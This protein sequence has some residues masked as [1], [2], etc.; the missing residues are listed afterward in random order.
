MPSR[1]YAKRK[2]YFKKTGKYRRR[3]FKANPVYFNR[4]NNKVYRF[5]RLVN[6]DNIDVTSTIDYT[7]AYVFKLSDV[8][9]YTEFTSLYDQYRIRYV[10]ITWY[11]QSDSF[12][13]MTAGSFLGRMYTTLDF[14]DATPPTEPEIQQMRYTKVHKPV[15]VIK[16][17]LKPRFLNAIYN[18]GVT[19]AYTL[20]NSKSWI[21]CSNPDVQHYG[22]KIYINKPSGSYHLTATVQL[23][24][25]LEF[26]NPR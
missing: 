16:R 10:K 23:K 18:N 14:D 4:S 21:D 2:R 24:Y 25:Y 22:V 5:T 8:T 26:K 1:K 13:N 15:G 7:N 11:L 19:T 20:G 9:N 17:F 3:K 6:S 12:V